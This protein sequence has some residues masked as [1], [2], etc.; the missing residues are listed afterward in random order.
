MYLK[1][2]TSA[3]LKKLKYKVNFSYMFKII[4]GET[5]INLEQTYGEL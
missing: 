3:F 5:L 2:K 1:N 4:L